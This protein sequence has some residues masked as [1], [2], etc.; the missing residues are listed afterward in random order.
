VQI[1]M[2]MHHVGIELARYS[3]TPAF[4]QRSVINAEMYDPATAVTAGYLDK[5]VPA[6][7]LMD[8]AKAE[9]T[10]LA[11]L[12]MPA[13]TATKLKARAQWLD[14]LDLAIDTDRKAQMAMLAG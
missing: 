7:Q 4:F 13:H 1:G 3:L 8:A 2:T 6:E 5:I 11:G 12:V 9:A 10:R 14:A